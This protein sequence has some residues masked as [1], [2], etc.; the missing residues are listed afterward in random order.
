MADLRYYVRATPLPGSWGTPAESQQ[1]PSE[2][3]VLAISSS[4]LQGTYLN[5]R[6]RAMYEGLRTTQEPIDVLGGTIYLYA[7]PPGTRLDLGTR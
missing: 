1:L 4:T 5:P 6:L 2:P 7:F 3:C